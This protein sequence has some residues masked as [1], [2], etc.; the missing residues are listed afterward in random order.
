MTTALTLPGS[1]P[2]AL[3]AHWLGGV[4]ASSRESYGRD[5]AA[6][7]A[8]LGVKTPGD[9]ARRLFALPQGEANSLVLAWLRSMQDRG[10]K[11]ASVARKLA[12]VS[13][14]VRLGNLVGM[15]PWTLAVRAPRV[16]TSVRPTPTVDEFGRVLA[17]C[18][19]DEERA[20]V[21]LAGQ[22][23]FRRAEIASMTCEGLDAATC[24]VL[25]RRKGKR[26]PSREPVSAAMLATLSS[27]A[28]LR[29]WRGPL[30]LDLRGNGLSGWGVWKRLRL[31]HQ[32]A[33][34]PFHGAHALRRRAG[35][36]AINA[37]ESVA[38][39]AAYMGHA[40]VRVLTKHY[41]SEGDRRKRS[42]AEKLSG[43]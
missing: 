43:G 5:V 39:A 9:A 2:D 24:S 29:G 7:A 10:L 15:V 11:P 6:F 33:G 18:E 21:M 30:F 40:D 32:R 22:R 42:L 4:A 25:V 31:I 13:S 23:G 35:T 8:W 12:A 27:V 3:V 14:L 34:V 37:A 41:D 17:A 19:N 26:E 38:D 1:N 20:L 36:D 28:A 16:E